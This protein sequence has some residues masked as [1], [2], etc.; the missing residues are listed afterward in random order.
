MSSQKMLSRDTYKEYCKYLRRDPP[1]YN[2]GKAVPK[3]K[4]TQ[5]R[6]AVDQYKAN[7]SNQ[8]RKNLGKN[9]RVFM[10]TRFVAAKAV[11]A[12]QESVTEA[13]EETLAA[14]QAQSTEI[15][16][17]VAEKFRDILD[18]TMEQP[19]DMDDVQW[20]N[21]CLTTARMAQGQANSAKQRIDAEKSAQWWMKK[22]PDERERNK[23][24][25]KKRKLAEELQTEKA[26]KLKT[27][28]VAKAKAA[29]AQVMAVAK[30]K[31]AA[32]HSSIVMATTQNP[33]K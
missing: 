13:K 16:D 8:G 29:V 22:Y 25:E 2:S 26:K 9:Q 30:A 24:L 5:Y 18:G 19:E 31:A 1:A 11:A 33:G 20:R 27:E 21:R 4:V 23:Q 17:G 32:A 15:V 6:A 7:L 3:E 14:L 28:A 12:V 10:S